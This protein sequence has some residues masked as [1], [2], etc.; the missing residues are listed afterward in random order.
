MAALAAHYR[1]DDKQRQEAQAALD[2]AEARADAWF[3]DRE[4]AEKVR[5]YLADLYHVQQV[6]R[7]AS[8]LRYEKELAYKQR[9]ELEKTRRELVAALDA[10]S[11]ALADAWNDKIARADQRQER[12]DF[13]KQPKSWTRLD[14]INFTTKWGLTVG[15]LCLML[16]LFT[17]AAALGGAFFLANIYFSLPPWPGVPEPSRVEGHYYIVNKNLVELLACL[18]VASTPNGL[19]VG[20]DALLFGWL[21]RRWHA[22]AGPIDR[23]DLDGGD[24][25]GRP[26]A[27]T[28]RD[29]DRER[30]RPGTFSGKER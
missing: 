8:A 24:H 17:P 20:L 26:R 11:G 3:R 14:V 19:W 10:Q 12:G 5:K 27:P 4:N 21:R 28:D 7:D 16:G 13:R 2:Q 25:G 6:E 30:R 22:P 15:G 29:R 18:V 9:Q 23:L 1:F